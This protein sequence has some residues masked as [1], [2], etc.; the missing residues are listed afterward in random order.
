MAILDFNVNS[1]NLPKNKENMRRVLD[2]KLWFIL[3]YLQ[4]S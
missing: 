1:E 3:M 2:L 4:M